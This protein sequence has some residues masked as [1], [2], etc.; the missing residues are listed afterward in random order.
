MS[1]SKRVSEIVQNDHIFSAMEIPGVDYNSYEILRKNG[2]HTPWGLCKLYGGFSQY[3]LRRN[4]YF[5]KHLVQLGIQEYRANVI[6]VVIEQKFEHNK[7]V[8]LKKRQAWILPHKIVVNH[9]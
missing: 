5:C 1:F 6:T 3:I 2:L 9:F 4:V 8:N 7:I